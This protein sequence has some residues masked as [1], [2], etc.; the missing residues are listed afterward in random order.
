MGTASPTP[1]RSCRTEAAA[2]AGVRAR[3]AAAG[4]DVRVK[5]PALTA[6]SSSRV[7]TCRSARR[8]MRARARSSSRRPPPSAHDRLQT[9]RLRAASSASSRRASGARAARPC[10]PPTSC[11]SA[12]RGPGEVP[13]TAQQGRRADARG[14]GEGPLP[15]RRRGETAAASRATFSVTDRCD[16][17][18]TKVNQGPRAVFDREPQAHGDGPLR[19]LLPREG[20]DLQRAA[21]TRLT[22]RT[23]TARGGGLPQRQEVARGS[24]VAAVRARERAAGTRVPGARPG[25]RSAGRRASGGELPGAVGAALQEGAVEPGVGSARSGS[26]PS[27]PRS[28]LTL[29]SLGVGSLRI[30]P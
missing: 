25:R 22:T 14:A 1:T 7:A 3:V 4:G 15:D 26:E 10:R 20:A 16:G 8:W 21:R 23:T 19:P 2:V 28:K 13:A 18:I 6:S 30:A 27:M 24:A 9:A 11:W 29:V 5:L 12:P 17:T